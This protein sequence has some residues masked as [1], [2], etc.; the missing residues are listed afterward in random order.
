[1]DAAFDHTIK[2]FSRGI[3]QDLQNINLSIDYIPSANFSASL[4]LDWRSYENMDHISGKKE[5]DFTVSLNVSANIDYKNYGEF[6]W[7]SFLP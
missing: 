6:S 7:R 2:G 1:M 4:K 3:V 5:K